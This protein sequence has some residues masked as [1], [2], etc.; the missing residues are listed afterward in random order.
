M[1]VFCFKS[2]K[3]IAKLKYLYRYVMK[4]SESGSASESFVE[5]I[6]LTLAGVNSNSV[7]SYPESVIK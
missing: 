2:A 7:S 3:A 6:F 4:L 1:P 5:I